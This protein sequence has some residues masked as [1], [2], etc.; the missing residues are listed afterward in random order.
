MSIITDFGVME[1][2]MTA[3][4]YFLAFRV[5]QKIKNKKIIK[6]SNFDVKKY[7]N[8]TRQRSLQIEGIFYRLHIAQICG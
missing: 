6:N 2:K 1:M 5:D 8:M 3:Y 4:E 7:D